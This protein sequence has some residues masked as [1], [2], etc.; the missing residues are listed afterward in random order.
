MTS[1]PGCA[2]LCQ[3]RH[4]S[5][6]SSPFPP[7]ATTTAAAAAA[8]AGF[9]GRWRWNRRHRQRGD[10][11]LA[12][13]YYCVGVDGIAMVHTRREELL[14][15]SRGDV[16][17]NP[18]SHPTSTSPRAWRPDCPQ[19]DRGS[20][21]KAESGWVDLQ[22]EWAVESCRLGWMHQSSEPAKQRTGRTVAVGCGTMGFR[23]TLSGQS[24]NSTRPRSTTAPVRCDRLCCSRVAATRG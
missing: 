22:G 24:L 16:I 2:N 11:Q 20:C 17:H 8:A 14:S 1:A 13:R 12:C 9:G 5:F 19:Q 3:C 4:P 18:H 21:E 23:Q 10:S 7:R 15:T 6:S